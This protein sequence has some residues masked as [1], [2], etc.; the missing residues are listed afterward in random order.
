[1][2]AM[3]RAITAAIQVVTGAVAPVPQGDA[4]LEVQ[5]EDHHDV[6]IEKELE[7]MIEQD[8]AYWNEERARSSSGK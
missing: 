7:A 2:A 6:D 4:Q 3:R 5:P 8:T 1:M